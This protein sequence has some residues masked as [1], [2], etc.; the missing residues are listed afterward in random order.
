IDY[1]KEDFEAAV[2]RITNGDGVDIVLDAVG[3]R[4]FRKS[5]RT[6]APLGRL[7]LFG[8]SSFAPGKR[9]SLVAA[10]RGLVA[11]PTFRPIPLMNQNRGV[12]GINLGHLWQKVD[13]LRPMLEEIV[14]LIGQG[15]FDPV[16]DQH[17]AFE[18]AG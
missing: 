6:L 1:T 7:Y 2:H 10:L 11:L 9:R 15:T 4:S 18:R 8:V 5:Y 14:A 17:F 16:V 13:R 12:H 3:G